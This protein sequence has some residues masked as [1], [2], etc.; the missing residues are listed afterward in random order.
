MSRLWANSVLGLLLFILCF[1]IGAYLNNSTPTDTG[2]ELETIVPKKENDLNQVLLVSSNKPYD[3]AIVGDG[4]FMVSD[5]IQ[6]LYTRAGKLK[7]GAYGEIV[8]DSADKSYPLE[9]A[10]TI[11]EN[12]THV[13]IS[14]NGVVRY[15][16]HGSN[17]VHHSGHIQLANFTNTQGLV[18]LGDH[19]FAESAASG[20]PNIIGDP[21]KRG[22]G[23][24]RQGFL[25]QLLQEESVN[26][27]LTQKDNELSGQVVQ[28]SH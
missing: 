8:M 7:R 1:G 21:G 26:L 20:P 16:L 4:Y 5:G 13:S 11:P 14:L 18:N 24:L 10:L 12:A 25:E 17:Q 23:Q 3:V 19:L 15:Q 28:D 6:V 22:L 2:V 27:N 9:P